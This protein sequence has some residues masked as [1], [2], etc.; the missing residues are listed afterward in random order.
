MNF[1]LANSVEVK[2]FASG[3]PYWAGGKNVIGKSVRI[4]FVHPIRS[5]KQ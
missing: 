2:W 1:P 5:Y 4:Y 3:K